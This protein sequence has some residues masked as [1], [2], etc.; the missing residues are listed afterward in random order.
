[1]KKFLILAVLLHVSL[2]VRAEVVDL[3]VV[4]GQSNAVGF[5]AYKSEMGEDAR[6]ASVMF[7]WRVGDPPPDKHDSVSGGWTTL[8][9]QPLGDPIKPRKGRQYGNFGKPEGGFGPEVGFAREWL[10]HSTNRLAVVKA[11][12]SGTGIRKDWDHSKR[13]EETNCYGALLREYRQSLTAAAE[14]GIGFRVIG[15]LWIQGESDAKAE[16]APH[17]QKALSEMILTL[18][19]D[20]NTPEMPAMIA[21]NTRFQ[22]GRNKFMPAIVEAQKAVAQNVVNVVYVDTSKAS[23]INPAHYDAKGTLDV[24]R[25]MAKGLKQ[26]KTR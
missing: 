10:K 7:W 24:G 9:S 11:A 23:V 26:L 25:W 2:T 4:A 14:Q 15:F 20:L 5:D 8:R 22:E 3:I 19:Q 1:M 16:D 21:V 13:N 6:D 17:Y 12:F 18:R